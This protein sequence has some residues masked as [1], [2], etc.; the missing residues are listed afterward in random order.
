MDYKICKKVMA[1]MILLFNESNYLL[2]DTTEYFLRLF[3]DHFT[4][5]S[6]IENTNNLGSI[7][8]S[9]LIRD[10]SSKKIILYTLHFHSLLRWFILIFEMKFIF[11]DIDAKFNNIL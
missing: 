2:K 7:P 4:I 5:S 10:A 9:T 6:Q 11:G 8:D 1:S 3:D